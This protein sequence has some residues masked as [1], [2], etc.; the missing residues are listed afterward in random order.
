VLL[1]GLVPAHHAGIEPS[2][3]HFASVELLQLDFPVELTAQALVRM[4][5]GA[6][7]GALCL[8]ICGA[9]IMQPNASW[10]SQWS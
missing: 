8:L 5:H 9:E 1:A 2:S 6:S 10:T 3:E 7:H 4:S